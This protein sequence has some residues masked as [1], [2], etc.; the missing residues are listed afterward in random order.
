VRRWRQSS[1][2]SSATISER[3]EHLRAFLDGYAQF[4]RLPAPRKVEVAW[5]PFV[6]RLLA[7]WP[8]VRLDDDLPAEPGWFDP[9]QLEQVVINLLK[10]AAEAGGPLDGQALSVASLGVR[11][12]RLTIVDRGPGMSRR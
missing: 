1:S 10:N 11:G 8:A 6:D 9:G 2:G 12:V 4:A 5:R 7:L 3:T